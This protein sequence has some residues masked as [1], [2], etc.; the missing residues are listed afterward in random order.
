MASDGGV[1]VKLED[2]GSSALGAAVISGANGV[3][4][5]YKNVPIDGKTYDIYTFIDDTRND[6]SITVDTPGMVDALLVGGGG[7]GGFAITGGAG[8]GAVIEGQFYLHEGVND[9]VVG[10]GGLPSEP[11][12]NN[13]SGSGNHGTGSVL[14]LYAAPG[15]AGSGMLAGAPGAS[16]S[17]G[18]PVGYPGGAGTKGLGHPGGAGHPSSGTT[19]GA[20]GGGGAGEP[21]EDS[22]GGIAG[23]GGDGIPSFITGTEQWFGGG[24]GGGNG[25]SW[26]ANGGPG[27]RGGGANGSNGPAAT[28]INATP[29]T[30]GGAGGG[31]FTGADSQ[32]G[33]GGSGIVIV[34]VEV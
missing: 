29:N 3:A 24:G 31:G 21:G 2:A 19:G 13:L 12:V 11:N 7:G 22:P 4:T 18:R 28:G 14:G 16:G 5:A 10:K 9:V 17:G 20:G 34:R 25:G 26:G 27:G 30:G 23:K 15:G 1:W 6:L 8:A 33:T 32:G